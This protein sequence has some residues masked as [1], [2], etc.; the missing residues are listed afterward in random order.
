MRNLVNFAAFQLGWLACVL[1]GAKGKP[2]WGPA[3]AAA[4][5]ALHLPFCPRPWREARFLLAATLAGSAVDVLVTRLGFY[6]FRLPYSGLLPLW[7]VCLWLLFVST[8]NASMGW[9]RGRYAWG[10]ALG[11]IGAPLSYAAG[12]RLEAIH[13]PAGRAASLAGLG[14]AW[15]LAMPVL[16]R[17]AKEL[18]SEEAAA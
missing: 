8:F 11:A 9:L 4:A 16:L 12:A 14:L 5:L 15:G 13:F 6:A 1:G 10:A 2:L 7:I 18:S 3:A 17:L